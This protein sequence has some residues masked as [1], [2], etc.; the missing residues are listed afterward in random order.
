[1]NINDE[2]E[3][4]GVYRLQI[5]KKGTHKIYLFYDQH[6]NKQYCKSNTFISDVLDKINTSKKNKLFVLEEPFVDKGE[7]Y[8]FLW[9]DSLHL[10]LARMFYDKIMN[11]CNKTTCYTFPI[12]FRLSLFPFDISIMEEEP[13]NRKMKIKEYFKN[14]FFLFNLTDSCDKQVIKQ[15]KEIFN[16]CKTTFYYELLEK[17]VRHFYHSEL[18]HYLDSSLEDVIK[19][20]QQSIKVS[21]DVLYPFDKKLSGNILDFIENISCG[22]I[23]YYAF[24]IL[25]H[26]HIFDKKDIYTYYFY[27]GGYHCNVLS[28]VLETILNYTLVK[29]Y[30][31]EGESCIRME[32][33]L[34]Y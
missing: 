10:K 28:H 5:Y 32:G 3:I 31:S 29:D 4:S 18:K 15:I 2:I 34:I 23:E 14:L 25:T 19:I 6:N 17:D 26:T 30:E 22:L 7:T 16:K 24:L 11:M 33:S 12:D 20:K 1:M 8:E 9:Q 21:N 27:A 13:E